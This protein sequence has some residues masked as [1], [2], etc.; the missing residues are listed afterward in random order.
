MRLKSS[1][2]SAGRFCVG[3]W[4]MR[5]SCGVAAYDLHRGAE[6]VRSP[7]RG[8]CSTP[9]VTRDGLKPLYFRRRNSSIH[10]PS[11]RGVAW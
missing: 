1:G 4:T 3:P 2:M 8:R 11:S 10:V 5:L 6:L 7:I 9:R